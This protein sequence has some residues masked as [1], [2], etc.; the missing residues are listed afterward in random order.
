MKT[1]ITRERLTLLIILALAVAPYFIGLGSSSLWDSN[2]AFYAETPREMI[3]SGDYVNPTF[4]YQPR[5]NKP[6]L[7]YW[8]VIFSYKVF[9]VSELAERIPIAFGAIVL[10]ATAF[11][12]GRIIFSYEAAILS[13]TA[14]A[15]APRFLMF[16]RRIMIDL[17]LAMFMALALLFFVLA[18]KHPERRR[19]F[20]LLMYAALGFGILTKGPVAILLPATAFVIYL[21][22]FRQLKDVSRLMPLWGAAIVA[23]IVLPWYVAVYAE[24]GWL[25]IKSFLMLDNISRYTEGNW[26]P[27]RGPLFY[28]QVALGDLFPWSLFLP[29]AIWI[30]IRRR[31]DDG[32]ERLALLLVI[33]VG[34]IIVFFSLSRSKED[35]YILPIFPAA[36]ALVGGL[37]SSFV[38]EKLSTR[39]QQVILWTAALLAIV[40]L[41]TGA[42]ALY[43]FGQTPHYDLAG[44]KAI[45]VMALAGGFITLAS[46]LMRKWLP[47]IAITALT[48][49]TMN[50]IF[51]LKTLPDFE[52]FKPVRPFC[53][54]I[55][56]RASTDAM[57]GYYRFASP[58]M[59]FY[60]RRHIFE[61]YQPQELQAAFSS[62]KD[63]Y[64]LMTLQDY[65]AIKDSLPA[66]T[67][68]LAS[69][70]VFQVKLKVVLEKTEPPQ[71]VLI[72][73]RDGASS[74]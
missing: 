31:T 67:Y 57:I 49:V 61:Y 66:Q 60:L 23:V 25:Y 36:A 19:L 3:E 15:I 13:A 46:L 1:A 2:E 51:T 53:E 71:V 22:V 21:A 33:W 58:S 20:L 50:W 41:A 16:S 14:L 63:V 59:V 69:R 62:G 9:G 70:P 37:L 72:S 45:G 40:I 32:R 11:A 47:A 68:I 4:N 29:A 42:A 26:G 27:S 12:L 39:W 5:F 8:V 64:C 6:P 52:R 28:L 56:G 34:V 30:R 10:V 74:Y 7:S 73:N 65:E 44:A 48:V 35:L 54:L 55:A 17:Y 43:F 24:H 18:E 38:S